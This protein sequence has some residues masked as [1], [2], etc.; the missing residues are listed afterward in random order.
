MFKDGLTYGGAV[1]L[2]GGIGITAGAQEIAPVPHS[3]AV[4]RVIVTGSSLKRLDA[5][6]AMP[7]TVI[8]A[9]EFARKGI[10]SVEEMLTTLSMN[11]Q[12]TVAA[13]NVG[14]ET[15]G[16]SSANLRGLGDGRT[17]ILL[18]GR[19][20]PNHPYDG[21]SVDLY[22]IP[23]AAIDRIEVLRD[24]A[25]HLYGSDA[26]SG[27]IN[28]ITKRSY[29]GTA[30]TAE[31][32]LPEQGGALE[33]RLSAT[34]GFG[35]LDKDGYN[36]YGAVDHHRQ[37]RLEATD[38][39]F[40]ATGILPD[41][42]ISKT[43]GTTFPANFFS[44]GGLSGNPGFASGCLPP[45]SIPSTTNKTC[46]QDYARFV[47]DV[48]QTEQTSFLGRATV[49]LGS[50]GVGTLEYLHAESENIN[51]IAPPPMT[52]LMMHS[53]SKW[54]PGGSGGTPAVAGLNG[55][56]L[57]VS[58]RTTEGGKR[59]ATNLGKSDRVLASLTGEFS[60]WDYSIGVNAARTRVTENL[61]G[62]YLNDIAIRTGIDNGILNPFGL[63]DMAG[64][65]LLASAQVR[66]EV[67]AATARN[68][69]IDLR[70]TRDLMAL[71]AGPLGFALGL[72]GRRETSEFILQRG[73]LD[74]MLI[75][76]ASG[77]VSAANIS[78]SRSL[79]ALFSE[80]NIPLTRELEV[81]LAAR[82]DHYSDAGKS[83]NPKIGFRFQPTRQWV[84]RG[85]ANT[86]F[87]AP[88]LYELNGPVQD[89]ITSTQYNDPL[90]C[91]DGVPKAGVNPNV[92]CNANLPT[93]SGGNP[94]LKPEK[95]QSYTVGVV[96]EPHPQLTLSLDYAKIKIR[97]VIGEV[98]Y[99]SI[100]LNGF[101]QYRSRY[102]YNAAGTALDY[103]NTS[104][105]GNGGGRMTQALDVTANWR[106]PSTRL[107]DFDG[108][109]NG[110]YVLKDTF[111][112]IDG[113]SQP[114]IGVYNGTVRW[115]HN[116]AIRWSKDVWTLTLSQRYSGGY[117]DQNLVADQY[118]QKVS[119]Y[120]VWALT[121]T[122]SGLKNLQLSAGIKNLLN[123]AP[124][125]S[126]QAPNPQTGYD[127]RFSSPVGRAVY[128]RAN[129]QYK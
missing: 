106:L 65:A 8:K 54:Y 69:G 49:K 60:G 128:L 29:T 62:G 87:R 25:S 51:R 55:E 116:A 22:S 12:S 109:F 91:P 59:E 85:S 76:R 83:F 63:Q 26:I 77:L 66:G 38:R 86:G 52:G 112:D 95:A 68:T 71:P 2:L 17:L 6:T 94:Q 104:T 105:L 72:E 7:V 99:E 125:F 45:G 129:Y 61:T 32:V 123:T 53:N 35:D 19:R 118:K 50:Q 46:R 115:R 1:L 11:Q 120:S 48:P 67:V 39:A 64:A 36:V 30:V 5:E 114:N 90:L 110:T 10:T 15:G 31:T 92:S 96:V 113:V 44:T 127:P 27:V 88:T 111:T 82:Y 14:M 121:G 13:G 101:D 126:N 58:W 21:S 37:A 80:A 117:V 79:S 74:Q 103:I 34:V 18:N 102:H 70:F 23:F 16:K 42:G 20:L 84:L 124:P 107:G 24:G 97:D 100:I 108:W 78:G 98:L 122:Y 47:D 81:Q 28:F 40:S 75:S 57:N 93:R 43:S 73:P 3:D 9:E 33:K 56:D 4:Q 89:S 41:K 119:A